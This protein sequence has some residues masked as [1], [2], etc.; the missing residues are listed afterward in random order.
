M[1][2][3]VSP[4]A[5][6][7][8]V[9]ISMSKSKPTGATKPK[10]EVRLYEHCNLCSRS[11][12]TA[13]VCMKPFGPLQPRLVVYA[14]S[15]AKV[16]DS[17][18]RVCDRPGT[19]RCWDAS[20]ARGRP[21]IGPAGQLLRRALVDAGYSL[22]TIMFSNVV[23]CSGGNPSMAEI[24]A[25]RRY[26]LEELAAIDYSQC[27]AVVLLGQDALKSYLNDGQVQIKHARLKELGSIGP[28]IVSV[29]PA[30]GS[31]INDRDGG[32]GRIPDVD[33]KPREAPG[34]GCSE[35]VADILAPGDGRLSC[36]LIS[37]HVAVRATYHPSAALGHHDPALYDEI[38]SDFLN[39]SK[40]RD[41]VKPVTVAASDTDLATLFGQPRAIA[42]DLEWRS[43]GSIRM[44]GL[45]DGK[46]NVT[47]LDP[48]H[49]LH[50][51][52]TLP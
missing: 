42:L 31:R 10:K 30:E 9:F 19:Q 40:E 35:P 28:K 49:A 14:E 22:E 7:I 45:S 38:V 32:K 6:P 8:R 46:T 29:E 33:Q 21:L 20:H 15:P 48:I 26:F 25:C 41:Q 43:D 16:E 11:A 39:I 23:R 37:P 47:C 3:E 12:N 18:C 24:R 50:W 34:G 36:R 17:W 4:K 27:E 5:C 44:I 52:K 1:R 2:F 13:V 51:L